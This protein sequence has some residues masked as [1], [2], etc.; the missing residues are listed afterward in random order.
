[1]VLRYFLDAQTLNKSIKSQP[2]L[3]YIQHDWPYSSQGVL[4][5]VHFLARRKLEHEQTKWNEVG[6]GGGGWVGGGWG[7]QFIY[8]FRSPFWRLRFFLVNALRLQQDSSISSSVQLIICYLKPVII[9]LQGGG[10]GRFFFFLG[11][12][13]RWRLTWYWV[14]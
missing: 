9:Y 14:I 3:S 10:S 13:L 1:M 6:G 5:V 4:R 7:Q 12:W 2:A 11:W 8:S